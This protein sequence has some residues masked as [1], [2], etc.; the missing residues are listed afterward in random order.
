MR[1]HFTEKQID[2]QNYSLSYLEG[3]KVSSSA[4]ILFLHGWSIS[5]EPY[6]ESLNILA[7]RYR[8]IAPYLPGSHKSTSPGLLQD[9][10]DYAKC[11]IDFVNKLELK[12]FHL[13]G[14]SFGGA[15]AIALAAALRDRPSSLSL[16]ASAGIPLGSLQEVLLQRSIEIP[17]QIGE[18]KLE[19]V[20]QVVRALL[21]N[22]FFNPQYVIQAI[23]IALEKDVRPLLSQIECPSLVLW[24]EN[25]LLI[26]L[27]LGQELARGIKGSQMRVLEG[28]YHEWI[29]F[30]PEKLAAII[31]EFLDEIEAIASR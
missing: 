23:W 8:V 22:C 21:Y 19:P 18:M 30:H 10:N 7:Q 11:M 28:E 9:Y 16:V 31:F 26:P 6:Q 3:G 20:S 4:P 2:F 15:V 13:I 14:H 5:V 29:V 17:A 25:D 12:K 24:G 27:K 1:N